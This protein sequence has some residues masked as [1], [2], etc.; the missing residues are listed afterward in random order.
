MIM[1]RKKKRRE[2]RKHKTKFDIAI[3]R[4]MQF[5]TN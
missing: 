4:M 5:E 3:V 2:E 1:G